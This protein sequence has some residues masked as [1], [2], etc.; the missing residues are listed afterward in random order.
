MLEDGEAP[1]LVVCTMAT[2]VETAVDVLSDVTLEVVLVTRVDV[3][4]D[5]EVDDEL[6]CEEVE[7]VD[8]VVEVV[9]SDVLVVTANAP[10]VVTSLVLPEEEGSRFGRACLG[11]RLATGATTWAPKLTATPTQTAS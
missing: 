3:E 6:I 11:S 1:E 2:F 4:D 10:L 5:W 8:C 9:M 7:V